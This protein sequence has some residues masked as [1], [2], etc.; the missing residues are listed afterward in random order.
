MKKYLIRSGFNP[1]MNYSPIY[2]LSHN[3]LGGNSGNLLYTYG[4]MNVLGKEDVMFIP[5]YHKKE[6]S[7][8]EIDFINEECEAFILP[9]ADA[10]RKDFVGH[11]KEYIKLINKLKIPCIVVGAGLRAPFEPDLNTSFEFD[12]VVCEFVSC[13]LEHSQMLGLRGE[14]TARYLQKLGFTPEKDFT[15]IGCPSLY[16][17]GKSLK[18]KDKRQ[19]IERFAFNAN[20]LAPEVANNFI[21]NSYQQFSDI[22]LIQQKRNELMHMYLGNNRTVEHVFSDKEFKRL[23]SEN[24]IR[25]FLNVPMWIQFMENMDMFL[26]NRFHGTV[27]AILAGI[28]HAIIPFDARTRELTEFHH[29]SHINISDIVSGANILDY[30][31]NLDF[32][33]FEKNHER[34]LIHYINFLHKNGL[35]SILDNSLYV[36]KGESPM[37]KN[38]NNMDLNSISCSQFIS[39][40][41]CKLRELTYKSERFV[42]R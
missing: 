13:V 42:P 12:E 4:V 16:T 9:L 11:L 24:R 3:M 40:S 36:T 8:S 2:A 14:I 28:P 39:E 21:I 35:E 23:N 18:I 29:I 26:G 27:A 17:Y 6:W 25:F 34:N 20:T 31:D 22:Y 32:D 33:T 1:Y 30:I 19:N 15:V 38:C 10:F 7:D 41:Q 5:T 37:E